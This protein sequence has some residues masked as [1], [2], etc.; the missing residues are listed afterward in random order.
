M[1][2]EAA[3]LGQAMYQVDLSYECN[4]I[5][6]LGWPIDVHSPVIRFDVMP[7][8]VV[9]LPQPFNSPPDTDG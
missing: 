6:R 8:L 3:A 2:P 5:H 1:I 4:L 7:R 9:I